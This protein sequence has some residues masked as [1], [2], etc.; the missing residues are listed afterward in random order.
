MFDT[1]LSTQVPKQ[2][3]ALKAAIPDLDL[4]HI[5]VSHSHADHS[6]GVKFWKEEDTEIVAHA[7]FEE[8]QRYLTELQDYFWGRN[9]TLFPF[10]PETPPTIGLIAYGGVEPTIKVHNGEP[11]KFTQGGVDFE[12]YALPGAEG[13]DNI[14][15]VVSSHVYAIWLL[16][17]APLLV[18]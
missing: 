10:M 9:R 13:A 15:P 6:G 12:I 17:H 3:K 14:V 16:D 5:I 8:E 1:G 2:M 4:S 7:E 18:H 11:Y